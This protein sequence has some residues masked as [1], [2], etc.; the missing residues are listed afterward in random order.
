MIETLLPEGKSI[1]IMQ[2]PIDWIRSHTSRFVGA[3]IITIQD[4]RG[5]ILID[6][7]KAR[8]YYF[9]HQNMVLKGNSALAYFTKMQILDFDLRKYT[10]HEFTRAL[11]IYGGEEPSAAVQGASTTPSTEKAVERSA[12]SDTGA[13]GAVLNPEPAPAHPFPPAPSHDDE[14]IA[15]DEARIR[16]IVRQPGVEGVAIFRDGME[17]ISTGNVDFKKTREK[18]DDRLHWGMKLAATMKK[19][20]FLQITDQYENGDIIIAPVQD[21]FMCIVTSTDASLGSIRSLIRGC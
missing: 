7:G 6:K 3:V 10:P 12:A 9:Q 2:A 13:S 11:A 15:S 1:G 21:V 20:P 18:I 5:F 16:E 14:S 19:G 17:I 8:G 4:G